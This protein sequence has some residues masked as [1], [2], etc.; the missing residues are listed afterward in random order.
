MSLAIRQ[1]CIW[2]AANFEPTPLHI[3]GYGAISF[4][5]SA[6]TAVQ[7]GCPPGTVHRCANGSCKQSRDCRALIAWL[8]CLSYLTFASDPP[9]LMR[10]GY[11]KSFLKSIPF[12][13]RRSRL[14][15]EKS[16][17]QR[18]IDTIDQFKLWIFYQLK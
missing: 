13:T 14:I 3:L 9:G 10:K 12:Q 18:S 4:C 7:E 5:R 2:L 6:C 17:W 8:L 11:Q 15:T 16:W 1:R